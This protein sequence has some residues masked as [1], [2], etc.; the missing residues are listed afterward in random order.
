MTISRRQ[1][2]HFGVAAC[3]FGVVVGTAWAAGGD[4][5]EEWDWVSGRTSTQGWD[6]SRG[7]ATGRLGSG[8]G[9]VTWSD[10]NGLQSQTLEVHGAK[11]GRIKATLRVGNS[12]QAAELLS[13]T[14]TKTAD[15]RYLYESLIV[16]N[17]WTFVAVTRTSRRK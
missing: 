3:L 17:Q 7:R 9:L 4:V 15:G 1:F 11:Q 13:G 12:D 14:Y 8:G 6:V 5:Q 2:L 16:S 10:S